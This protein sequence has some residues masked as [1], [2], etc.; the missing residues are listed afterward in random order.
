MTKLFY[1]SNPLYIYNEWT[2]SD[3]EI[4]YAEANKKNTLE[5][6]RMVKLDDNTVSVCF[7]YNEHFI[8]NGGG[9]GE[10]YRIY[11]GVYDLTTKHFYTFQDLLKIKKYGCT[12]HTDTY[13]LN[14]IFN[15]IFSIDVKKLMG[16]KK[17][18]HN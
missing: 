17:Y 16:N 18:L 8:E 14:K 4:Y 7:S 12:T 11:N 15:K 6:I 10:R 13:K 1:E 2:G 3:G 5:I 9:I